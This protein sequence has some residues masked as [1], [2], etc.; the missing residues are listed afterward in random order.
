[1]AGSCVALKADEKKSI[2]RAPDVPD[3]RV[4]QAG[5]A[6][7]RCCGECQEGH[8]RHLFLEY[9]EWMGRE[10]LSGADEGVALPLY[11]GAGPV[12]LGR[13]DRLGGSRAGWSVFSD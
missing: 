8:S 11:E 9:L 13:R 3:A 10:P 1:M 12:E 2:S 7:R 4:S 6:G 5:C